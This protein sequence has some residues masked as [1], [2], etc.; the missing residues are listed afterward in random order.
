MDQVGYKEL[1]VRCPGS[2]CATFVS[3]AFSWCNA[4]HAAPLGGQ[5]SGERLEK[6][7]INVTPAP[8]LTRLQRFHQGMIG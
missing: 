3:D 4:E 7:F 5:R 2:S 8:L 1:T 6:Q